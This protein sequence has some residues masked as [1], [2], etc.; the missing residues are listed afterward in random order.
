TVLGRWVAAALMVGGV[1]LLGTVTASFASW[2]VDRVSTVRSD[3][4]ALLTTIARLEAKIDVLQQ[5]TG[6]GVSDG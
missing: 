1:A 4:E 2:L 3:E 5:R 6:H